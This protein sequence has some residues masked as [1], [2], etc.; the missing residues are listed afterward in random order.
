MPY[1]QRIVPIEAAL[2]KKSIMLL[3][4]RRSGKTAL[5]RHQ[6]QADQV[7]D[8]LKA[9]QFQALSYRP[10]LIRERLKPQDKLVVIDEI[11]KLPS[12]M[13]EVHALIEETSCRFL[14]TGSSARK[15]RRTHTALLAGRTRR[16]YLHPFCFPEV[17]DRFRLET[18]LL[19][20]GLPSAFLAETDSEAI[21]ELKDYAGD[22]LREEILSE[23]VVRKIEA[24]SRFLM[25]A[26]RMNGELL[27]FEAVGS[28]AQVPSRTV[29]EYFSVLEDTLV[30]SVLHPVRFKGKLS[31]KSISTGKFYFFDCGVLNALLGRRGFSTESPEFGSL[32]ETWVYQELRAYADYRKERDSIEIQFW[33]SPSGLEVDFI[34][35]GEIAIE[36]KASQSI[37]SRHLRGLC[38]FSQLKP[39]KKKWVVCRE[40]VPRVVDGIEIL[41]WRY[42]AEKLWA[43]E[44]VD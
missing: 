22:Y 20:G 4:P 12:L 8:L 1:L 2:K 44:L 37:S 3:G 35:N 5:I 21:E 11:Q 28:D 36:V 34:V 32:F 39:L 6:L 15:L 42:F 7:Y 26:A 40:R 33:R 13:D 9:D 17:Q 30:G 16:F 18:Y 19:R 29:R 24:F 38:E 43:G 27:N 14:L 10:S 25:I 41:P 23:A 31:R